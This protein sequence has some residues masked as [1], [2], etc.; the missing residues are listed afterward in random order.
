MKALKI[1]KKIDEYVR[2][3]GCSNGTINL[4][5]DLIDELEALENRSCVSCK[6]LCNISNECEE[7]DC[8]CFG[9]IINNDDLFKFSCNKW[10][11]KK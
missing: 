8:P 3:Y 6:H 9:L 1:A 7:I 5:D 10:K 4:L 2:D 11:S